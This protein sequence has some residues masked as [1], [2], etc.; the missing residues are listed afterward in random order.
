MESTMTTQGT[1]TLPMGRWRVDPIAS[2]LA[3]R[4]RSMFGLVGVRGTFSG[5]DGALVVDESGAHGELRVPTATLNTN[6]PQRDKHLRSVDFFDVVEYPTMTFELTGVR[7]AEGNG[8]TFD[9]VLRIRENPLPIGG[10]LEVMVDD[11]GRLHLATTVGV[12]REAAGV[13]WNKLGMV[14]GP[15]KLRASIVLEPEAQ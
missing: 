12:D 9:G 11:S 3:F 1:G 14:R 2:E 10:P 13:G 6:N 7:P 15:A 5:Y 4:A 8:L